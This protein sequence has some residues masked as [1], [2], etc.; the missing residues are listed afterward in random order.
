MRKLLISLI[1]VGIVAV[2]LMLFGQ[3]TGEP[4]LDDPGPT[5]VETIQQVQAIPGKFKLAGVLAGIVALINA[6][7]AVLRMKSI[8]GL[9]WDRI[10][11]RW[12][13]I[14]LLTL[15]AGAG[16]LTMILTG[17][18]WWVALV[19]GLF[20]GSTALLNKKVWWDAVLNQDARALDPEEVD[21]D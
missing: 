1:V 4:I 8:K 15:S 3:S 12:R 13:I 19:I 20:T 5:I 14:V 9:L 18:S 2:P 11:S 6:L 16:I 10:P 17:T 7:I 21:I